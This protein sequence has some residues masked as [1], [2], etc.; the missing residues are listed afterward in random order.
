MGGTSVAAGADWQTQVDQLIASGEFKKAEKVM[1]KLSKKTKQADA[2]RIDSLKTIMQRIRNDFNIT[3]EQGAKKIR[4]R[5]PE[6][7]DAQIANWKATKAL[8]VMTI[9]GQE[10][11]FRK[12]VGN[13]WL[14]G[15]EF[16]EQNAQDRDETYRT[17]RKY[18]LQ[19]MRTPA[20]RNGVRDWRQVNITFSLDVKADAVPAGETLRVWMPLPYENLRQR[21]IQYR[22]G[23]HEATFSQGSKHHTVYMEAVAEAGKP[24]HF[25]YSFSYEVG[26]RHIAQQDLLAM[27]EPYDVHSEVYQ[28]YTGNEPRHVIITDQMRD[29]A[30]Q[31]VGD[32]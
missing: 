20:D 8:E 24:T 29:L 21:N 10:W 31:I 14:L 6:A 18:Y 1:D 23:N 32:E 22:G 26:E 28:R 13:L 12:S 2:V 4:E 16:A 17:R 9:D 27:V 25:E 30:H 15:Q 19:A 7:T 5:M 3:P 11:W